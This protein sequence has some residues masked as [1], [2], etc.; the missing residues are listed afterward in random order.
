MTCYT[1]FVLP[2]KAILYEDKIDQAAFIQNVG[3]CEIRP[4]IVQAWKVFLLMV[5]AIPMQCSRNWATLYQARWSWPIAGSHNLFWAHF[6]N[7]LEIF[8]ARKAIFS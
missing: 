5:S 6:S 1:M 8:W 4:K 3:S 2:N 7:A